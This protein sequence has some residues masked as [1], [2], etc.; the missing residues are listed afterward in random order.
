V[1][2]FCGKPYELDDEG[3][4]Q[5]IWCSKSGTCVLLDK[6]QRPV[7]E[8]SSDSDSL[9]NLSLSSDSDGEICGDDATPQA[10]RCDIPKSKSKL[11]A[12]Q[13]SQI[14]Q[15]HLSVPKLSQT[16]LAEWARNEFHLEK[17]TQ[18]TVSK[19]LAGFRSVSATGGNLTNEQVQQIIQKSKEKGM[20]QEKLRH[21]SKVRFNLK[22]LPSQSTI[23]NILNNKRGVPESLDGRNRGLK[24]KRVV[25]SPELDNVLV[26]WILQRQEN[27]VIL[28]WNL[29]QA[30]A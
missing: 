6:Q 9:N 23:S 17:L 27:R 22:N 10:I 28:T 4:G 12:E 18:A 30:K 15:R 5:R 1:H 16:K 24:R 21:W 8:C 19:V 2:P 11:S 3:H 20:T 26:E 29:I 7:V 25:K 13:R 14:W